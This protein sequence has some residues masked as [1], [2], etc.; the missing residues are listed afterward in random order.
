MLLAGQTKTFA[1]LDVCY[2][3]RDVSFLSRNVYRYLPFSFDTF[4]SVCFGFSL[5]TGPLGTCD[6]CLHKVRHGRPSKS[7]TPDTT[8]AGEL[9]TEM[10]GL[11]SVSGP[12]VNT[13]TSSNDTAPAQQ[14][15]KPTAETDKNETEGVIILP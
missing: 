8:M 13:S 9:V 4:I 12:G 1:C 2:A 7:P 6:D 15:K 14:D 5:C 3:S 11:L 10:R